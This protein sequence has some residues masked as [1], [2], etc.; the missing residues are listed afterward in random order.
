MNGG[1]QMAPLF[2]VMMEILQ[3]KTLLV[4]H[5]KV[6]RLNTSTINNKDWFKEE[7]VFIHKH[8]S[9]ENCDD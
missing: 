4:K 3:L 1:L 6:P 2:I 5:N 8:A 9:S 7:P